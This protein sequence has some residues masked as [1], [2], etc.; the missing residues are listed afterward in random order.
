MAEREAERRHAKRIWA[1]A[2]D[3]N[4]LGG[5]QAG[6]LALAQAA[7]GQILEGF[8][9]ALAIPVIKRL[10]G[11]EALIPGR[12]QLVRGDPD[13]VYDAAHNPDGARALARTLP[14]LVG[15]AEVVCC[16]AVLEGKDAGGIVAGPGAGLRALRLHRDS[17]GGDARQRPA[18]RLGRARRRSWRSCARRPVPAPRPSRIPGPRGGARRRLRAS[19]G[20]VALAAGSHYLLGQPMD[21]EARGEL[22]TMMG[23][24]ALV[25]AVV[26]LL[27][28][29]VGYVFGLLFL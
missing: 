19:A 17:R 11:D 25:V 18:R 29:A 27:F 28:F 26:I 4:V 15:D 24:V 22:L 12:A 8:D 21:R 14:D 3:S 13:A 6:N 10:A 1:T 5:Y 20:A 9:P 23:L 2:V 7:A 16:L